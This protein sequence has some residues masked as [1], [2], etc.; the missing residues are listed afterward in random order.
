MDDSRPQTR[1]LSPPPP[2]RRTSR[3]GPNQLAVNWW[4]SIKHY[5]FYYLLLFG[6]SFPFY[7]NNAIMKCAILFS[8]DR[9]YQ[10]VALKFL[11][12]VFEWHPITIRSVSD[13]YSDLQSFSDSI[14]SH[15][16]RI[17][18]DIDPS[19]FNSQLWFTLSYMTPIVSIS[20]SR[21][22]LWLIYFVNFSIRAYSYDIHWL[23]V[24]FIWKFLLG[25]D[26]AVSLLAIGLSQGLKSI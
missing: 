23:M 25:G 17:W 14:D 11:W 7:T 15:M 24:L 21:W 5:H 16:I 18:H 9:Q 13:A 8:Y 19:I 4:R 1:W 3:R 6:F 26:V 20:L 10:Y 12:S 2:H 22:L